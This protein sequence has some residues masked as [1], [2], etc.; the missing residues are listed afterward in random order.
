MARDRAA[1]DYEIVTE[2][3]ELGS[4]YLD[5]E[6]SLSPQGSQRFTDKE[7]LYDLFPEA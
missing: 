2:R 6:N 3:I 7:V 5:V 1:L 4:Q